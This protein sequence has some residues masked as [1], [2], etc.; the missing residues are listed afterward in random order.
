MRASEVFKKLG[1]AGRNAATGV[2]ARAF[3]V[4]DGRVRVTAPGIVA[5]AD[6]LDGDW[7]PL[8]SR[9]EWE[10]EHPL[11]LRKLGEGEVLLDGRLYYYV[12]EDMK[13][14]GTTEGYANKKQIP[15]YTYYELPD[16]TADS[17]PE[18]AEHVASQ[19][20]PESSE[21]VANELLFQSVAMLL[22]YMHQQGMTVEKLARLSGLKPAK[23]ERYLT[24]QYDIPIRDVVSMYTALG[25]KLNIELKPKESPTSEPANPV[26]ERLTEP[27]EAGTWVMRVNVHTGDTVV[28]KWHPDCC[29]ADSLLYR[30]YRWHGPI[31]EEPKPEKV[32]PPDK[33]EQAKPYLRAYAQ[34]LWF[35]GQLKENEAV[36]R[37]L[38]EKSALEHEQGEDA[39]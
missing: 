6:S 7:Q 4:E 19:R 10:A 15:G 22:F 20:E 21:P 2:V 25:R 16:L 36:C 13:E 32:E 27:P 11:R 26:G 9:E 18:P 24:A 5:Y 23:V 28:R 8:L 31:P 30:T 38:G 1:D 33:W 37:L 17:E 14:S 39:P 3:Q 12:H 34:L 35:N 29:S